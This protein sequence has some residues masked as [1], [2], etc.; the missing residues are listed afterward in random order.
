MKSEG[1]ESSS[2][3]KNDSLEYV[4]SSR[5][6]HKIYCFSRF[7]TQNFILWLT[8]V[9]D[10]FKDFEWPSEKFL[11]TP[12]AFQFGFNWLWLSLKYQVSGTW[13]VEKIIILAEL[14]S[15]SQCCIF[16]EE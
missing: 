5:K 16:N 12:P 15:L 10:I 4:K 1:R 3:A 11:A 9:D 8:M 7:A 2:A 14:Y 13:L 6:G